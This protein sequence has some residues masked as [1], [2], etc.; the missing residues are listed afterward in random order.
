ME[1]SAC[2]PHSKFREANTCCEFM[3]VHWNPGFTRS[4]KPAGLFYVK[5]SRK[6]PV[7]ST[8]GETCPGDSCLK[9]SCLGP[10]WH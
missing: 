6:V 2:L 5:A 9:G 3:A 4:G 8:S 10:P 7:L 1:S